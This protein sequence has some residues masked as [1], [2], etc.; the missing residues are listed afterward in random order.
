MYPHST[1]INKTSE[2]G[3]LCLNAP[4][5]LIWCVWSVRYWRQCH[6]PLVPLP[7]STPTPPPSSPTSR[8]VH[9]LAPPLSVECRRQSL[10]MP[11]SP[12]SHRSVRSQLTS[13]AV[14]VCV[15]V[16]VGSIGSLLGTVCRVS[17]HS[18]LFVCLGH[19]LVLQRVDFVIHT[20]YVCKHSST[21]SVS[22]LIY[23]T[24]ASSFSYTAA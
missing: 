17:G 3:R 4:A 7:P 23:R 19:I 12:L 6:H 16:S 18:S 24:H 9:G 5:S 22:T 13:V 10:H 8:F 1:T 14:C 15:S 2:H 11:S 20:R 21:F